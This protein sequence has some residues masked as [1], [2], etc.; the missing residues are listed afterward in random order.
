M[1]LVARVH[2]DARRHGA[3]QGF[4]GARDRR[5]V[6]RRAAADEDAS[7]RLRIVDP[8]AEPLE[9]GQLER[10]RADRLP[11]RACVDVGGGG[12][13]V[14]ECRRPRARAG[15]IAEE[16]RMIEMADV[17]QDVLVETGEELREF[18]RA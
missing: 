1:R 2:H 11:P 14:A 13:Q 9:D 15:D 4:T 16:P 17:R 6:R 5:E 18:T 8:F 12:Y 7:G 3:D 10:A